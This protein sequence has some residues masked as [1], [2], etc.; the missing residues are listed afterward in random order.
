M[1]D[2]LNYQYFKALLEEIYERAHPQKNENTAQ[3]ALGKV[4]KKMKA[5]FSVTDELEEEVR[6]QV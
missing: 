3:T 1:A 2:S 6:R 5:D 4:W